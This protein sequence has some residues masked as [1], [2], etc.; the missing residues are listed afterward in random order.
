MRYALTGTVL[1]STNKLRL[2]ARVVN[3][4][5]GSVVWADSYEGNLI[6]SELLRV[7]AEI[8]QKVATTLAQPYG[9]VFRADASQSIDNPPENWGAYA[10]TLAYYAYRAGLDAK[11]HPK[12]REC[13]EDAVGQFP[14]YATAWALLSQTYVDEIR[15][16][17]PIAPASTP[18]SIERALEA[19]QKAVEL[20]PENVRGLQALMFA[21]YFNHDI[22]LALEVGERAIA[23]NPNDTEL[24]G[25]FG[26]RLALSGNWYRGCPLVAEARSRNP[27]P[28]AYYEAALSLCAYFLGNYEEAAQW[29]KKTGAPGNPNYHVIAA[30]VFAEGG[31]T[32]DAERERSWLMAN[33]PELVRNIRKVLALSTVREEDRSRLVA[34]LKKAGRPITD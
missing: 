29:I 3:Q 5:D 19:A 4:R 7:E 34:S 30:A 22:K 6:V 26:F 10:C 15:F 8:A 1:V 13:L 16:H 23:L 21:H 25:E 31:Y 14:N 32:A 24:M 9:V 27:G 33:E 12:I 17:Y 18:P 20:D 2:Q 28:L 11:T